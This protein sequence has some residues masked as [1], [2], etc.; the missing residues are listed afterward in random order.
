[1]LPWCPAHAATSAAPLCL[2][3]LLVPCTPLLQASRNAVCPQG[4]NAPRAAHFWAPDSIDRI[5]SVRSTCKSRGWVT[6]LRAPQ[7]STPAGLHHQQCRHRHGTHHRSRRC[8]AAVSSPAR[9]R[10]QHA[11]V[12]G[13]QPAHACMVGWPIYAPAVD[14]TA[15]LSL[16]LRPPM[17][18]RSLTNVQ[19][20]QL[21]AH[22]ASAY[23][24]THRPRA[25]RTHVSAC[26]ACRCPLQKAAAPTSLEAVSY[27]PG[28]GSWWPAIR[29]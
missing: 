24:R 2:C 23:A 29:L 3:R 16:P 20:C 8:C 22:R 15:S 14:S 6:R 10:S 9:A 5:Q 4:S 21:V 11:G 7:R 27:G 26:R 19:N 17:H 28:S 12:G 18:A 25:H 1:M 13:C